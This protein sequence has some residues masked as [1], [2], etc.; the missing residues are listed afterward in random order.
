MEK[1]VGQKLIVTIVKKEK[2]KKIIEATKRAG[3]RGGTT[4]YGE[5]FRR[6]DKDYFFGIPI[7]REREIIFTIVDEK[8]YERVL[9]CIIHTGCLNRPKQGISFVIDVDHVIGMHPTENGNRDHF[10]DSRGKER[11]VDNRSIEYDLIIT[12]VNKG[13]SEKVIE[14]SKRAGA[15]GGTIISGRGTGIHEKAKLFNILIEPEKEVVLTLINKEKTTEVLKA[16]EKETQL[17]KPGKG[18][19]FVLN[20]ERAVGINH[21]LRATINEHS[22]K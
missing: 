19:A 3:A 8:I 2:A 20:V 17:H 22:E 1:I 5:G 14:S 13:D 7:I 6:G 21:P 10:K 11:M 16:I 12:I 18:I 15:E 4:L 9:D